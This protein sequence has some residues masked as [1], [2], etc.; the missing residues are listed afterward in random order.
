[1]D[2]Q[3]STDEAQVRIAECPQCGAQV[4]LPV[5]RISG[6]CAFC[7]SKLIEKLGQRLVFDRVAP[8][9]LT[10]EQA[11]AHL[12]TAFRSALM[13]PEKLRKAGKPEDV[14]GVYLPFWAYDAVARSTYSAEIGINWWETQTYTTTD[15]KGKTVTRTRRVLR[16]EWFSSDGTHVSDYRDQLVS[17]STGLA[18]AEAN[19]L[20]PFDV[21]LCLPFAPEL[22]AGWAAERPS[23][24]GDEALNTARTEFMEL[25]SRAI[26]AFLPGDSQRN[27]TFSTDLQMVDVDLFLLPVW[28]AKYSHNGQVHR[29]LVN[30]Q[31]GEVVGQIPRSMA[32]V[33]S[34]I[35]IGVLVSAAIT[36]YMGKLWGVFWF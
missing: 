19:E 15:S 21:G 33:A 25:E 31:T 24:V 1:M 18:E 30:G 12:K 13:A 32:K 26:A 6:E 4:E 23:V 8:F 2:D 5:E 35:A 22:L 29:L 28:I 9:D 20:E 27:I 34:L 3:A 36:A 10:K 14:E 7:Q 17:A 16:T 11:G